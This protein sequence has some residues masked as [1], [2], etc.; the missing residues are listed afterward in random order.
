MPEPGPVPRLGG[1]ARLS[2]RDGRLVLDLPSATEALVPQR[3]LDIPAASH[4]D[5]ADQ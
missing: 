3:P 2:L 1:P 5:A 4:P